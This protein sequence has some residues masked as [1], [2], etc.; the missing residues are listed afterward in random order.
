MQA[1]FKAYKATNELMQCCEEQFELGKEYHKPLN[2]NNKG[3]KLCSSDGWHYCLKLTDC[4]NYYPSNGSKF[5]EI[6]VLGENT[7]EG[8][9]GITNHFK[10][11][12]EISRS[13]IEVQKLIE[14]EE[15]KINFTDLEIVL[16][17]A[18]KFPQIIFAGSIGLKLQGLFL[19]REGESDFDLISPYY[20]NFAQEY[21]PKRTN[22]KV[23]DWDNE[24]SSTSDFMEQSTF[25][26][27]GS[28][29]KYDLA[30]KPE[31]RYSIVIIDDIPVKVGDALTT[32]EAKIRY[33]LQGG[34]S[35]K[36][37]RKDFNDMMSGNFFIVN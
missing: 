9:K 28:T 17:I 27:Q 15:K 10:F 19:E 37:H 25:E 6:E 33:A 12:K 29:R 18:K 35:S 24:N 16:D 30:I 8:D 7:F 5:F 14:K 11:V 2:S 31:Q 34:K 26:F 22:N 1:P 20:I 3:I 13:D 4:E 32:W 36:K 21:H 23:N